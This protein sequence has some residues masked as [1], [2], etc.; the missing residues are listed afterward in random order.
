MT[1]SASLE[2]GGSEKAQKETKRS[3]GARP[4]KQWIPTKTYGTRS[5]VRRGAKP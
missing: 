2:P 3:T 1:D 5:R 4:R